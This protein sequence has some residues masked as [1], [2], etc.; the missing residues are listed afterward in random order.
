[1]SIS[2]RQDG[3]F[4]S[5]FPRLHITTQHAS[6]SSSCDKETGSGQKGD[7]IRGGQG[8]GKSRRAGTIFQQRV[9]VKIHVSCN[10]LR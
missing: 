6:G 9:K 4:V 10:M 3:A 8:G 7:K 2:V 1:M 5:F